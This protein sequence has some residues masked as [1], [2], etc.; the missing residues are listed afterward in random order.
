LQHNQGEYLP[1]AW[2]VEELPPV[3]IQ[4][5]MRKQGGFAPKRCEKLRSRKVQVLWVWLDAQQQGDHSLGERGGKQWVVEGIDCHRECD[6]D[7]REQDERHSQGLYR[8]VRFE[9]KGDGQD[10]KRYCW[11]E[12]A[13]AKAG[14]SIPG[15]VGDH[16]EVVD[17]ADA[18]PEP[19]FGAPGPLTQQH[20][21]AGN[22][23]Q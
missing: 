20:D 17:D 14:A 15:K 6:D 3:V 2:Q 22:S 10:Q 16:E 23:Q 1:D 5:G 18:E 8:A 19:C 12:M 11:H 9:E 13:R 4:Q 21:K 7:E